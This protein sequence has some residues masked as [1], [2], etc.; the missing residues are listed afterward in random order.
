VL[1]TDSDVTSE[2]SPSRSPTGTLDGEFGAIDNNLESA[3]T[4]NSLRSETEG[5]QSESGP[6]GLNVVY[7]P[8]N[9][10]KADII[11]IHGLGGTSRWTWTKNKNPELFWPL[12]FLPLEADLCLARILTFGYNSAFHKSGGRKTSV[13]DFAEA[14]LH[15]LKH[16]EDSEDNNLGI[17][18]VSNIYSK[19]RGIA[20]L[21]D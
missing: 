21:T 3:T 4:W 19:L 7:T 6:L 15:D 12:T 14:L 13:L 16:A 9:G 2:S 8:N 17:G 1:A 11:F 5:R 10:H 18:S 20:Y